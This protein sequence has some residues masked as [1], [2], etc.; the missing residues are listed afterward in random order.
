MSFAVKLHQVILAVRRVSRLLQAVAQ[1]EER[2]L[3]LPPWTIVSLPQSRALQL[4]SPREDQ[5]V[6]DVVIPVQP[7]CQR[8]Q[9]LAP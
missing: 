3:R 1:L 8:P 6:A 9:R 7:P 2:L 4:R 5:L